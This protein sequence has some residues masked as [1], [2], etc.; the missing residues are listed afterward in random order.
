MTLKSG[1]DDISRYRNAYF[2]ALSVALGSLFYG[3]DMSV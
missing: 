3:Y 2:L 1:L